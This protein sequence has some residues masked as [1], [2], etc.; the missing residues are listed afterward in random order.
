MIEKSQNEY[1]SQKDAE[2]KL[3]TKQD[4]ELVKYDIYKLELKIEQSKFIIVKWVS[5]VIISALIAQTG[6]LFTLMKI[7]V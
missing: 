3:S 4:I 5:T 6:V 7:F 1:L 2:I